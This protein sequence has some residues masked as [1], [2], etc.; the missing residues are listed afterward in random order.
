MPG[1]WKLANITPILKK[2]IDSDV[3]NYRPISLTSVFCNLFE[4]LLHGKMLDY[5]SAKKLISSQQHG[6]LTR[7]STCT[8]LLEVVDDWSIVLRNRRSIDCCLPM[9][10]LI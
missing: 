8:Q 9:S 1:D 7:P 6:F 3:S 4:R 10:I 5:L 2:G